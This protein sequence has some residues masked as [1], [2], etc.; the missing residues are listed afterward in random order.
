M[1]VFLL[2]FSREIDRPLA[3]IGLEI[4]PGFDPA[5]SSGLSGLCLRLTG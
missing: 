2:Q 1:L 4:S 5:R 3:R